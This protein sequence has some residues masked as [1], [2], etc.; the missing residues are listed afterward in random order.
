MKVNALKW[1]VWSENEFS[2]PRVLAYFSRENDALE[3]AVTRK[4]KNVRYGLTKELELLRIR[5]A[6]DE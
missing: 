5:S 3:F 6:Y 1:A 2:K 4:G